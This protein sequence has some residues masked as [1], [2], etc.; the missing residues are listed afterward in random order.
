MS[1]VYYSK[2]SILGFRKDGIVYD[3]SPLGKL[4]FEVVNDV[5]RDQFGFHRLQVSNGDGALDRLCFYF[6]RKNMSFGADTVL[7]CHS[8]NSDFM[9]S[10]IVDFVS[11]YLYELES[12]DDDPEYTV[13]FSAKMHMRSKHWTFFS[14]ST[15]DL[16]AMSNYP[17]TN[18]QRGI[19]SLKHEG[20]EIY[21]TITPL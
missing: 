21:P 18:I 4:R 1:D 9:S 15:K 14:L 11:T 2:G 13:G 20:I 16:N 6:D 12:L 3:E 10:Q 8:Y 17:Y 5:S 19:I 7:N